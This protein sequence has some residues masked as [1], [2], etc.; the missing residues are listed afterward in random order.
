MAKPDSENNF[1]HNLLLL[2]SKE[3]F[4]AFAQVLQALLDK[5]ILL[6]PLIPSQDQTLRAHLNQK[7]PCPTR[8]PDISG[9]RQRPLRLCGF[10]SQKAKMRRIDF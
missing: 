6:E 9:S 1:L 10:R 2:L 8:L 5:A 3:G 4:G 7:G